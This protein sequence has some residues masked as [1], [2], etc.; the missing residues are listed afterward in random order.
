MT[1]HR[2]S[3]AGRL[4]PGTIQRLRQ[5]SA[6]TDRSQSDLVDEAIAAHFARTAPAPEQAGDC[7]RLAAQCIRTAIASI[8]AGKDRR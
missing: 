5:L 1:A 4:A 8:E 7:L 6:A 2:K 3:W